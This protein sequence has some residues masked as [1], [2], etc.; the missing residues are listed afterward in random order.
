MYRETV[1]YIFTTTTM[2][3]S[4][5]TKLLSENKEIF[6]LSVD[7]G[8]THM[9]LSLIS[10]KNIPSVSDPR[11]P[12]DYRTLWFAVWDTT[13]GGIDKSL[14]NNIC[15]LEG[16]LDDEPAMKK[17]I[18]N[19]NIHVC[20]EHQEGVKNP[21]MLF[22]LMRVNFLSGYFVGYMQKAGH[23]V[24]FLAKKAKWAWNG[25]EKIVKDEIYLPSTKDPRY[26]YTY[27]SQKRSVIGKRRTLRKRLI[28]QY[29][30]LLCIYQ[31]NPECITSFSLT[32][33]I[34]MLNHVADAIL[35]GMA[36]ICSK[37]SSY[38]FYAIPIDDTIIEL[39]KS[40][41]FKT[42]IKQ[43]KDDQGQFIKKCLTNPSKTN[44]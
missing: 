18:G 44:K 5:I 41:K 8:K 10:Y 11:N 3:L 24:H 6:I 20:V 19:R 39:I 34:T 12:L 13:R 33:T 31:D 21:N 7:P 15:T 23:N 14:Q 37:L 38:K 25:F 1:S 29:T 32:C 28:T 26:Q 16:L 2:P 43:I 17:I 4:M 40:T 9:G 36:F 27:G 35:Q 42:E 22:H 30:N